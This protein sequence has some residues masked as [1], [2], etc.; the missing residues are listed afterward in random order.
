MSLR[1]HQIETSFSVS[2]ITRL[3]YRDCRLLAI[4]LAGS[5]NQLRQVLASG[6]DPRLLYRDDLIRAAT[7]DAAR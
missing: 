3:W 1:T 4:V 2:Q 6:Y 7:C 5:E